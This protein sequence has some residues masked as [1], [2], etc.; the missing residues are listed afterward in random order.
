MESYFQTQD[1]KICGSCHRDTICDLC[2][3]II[4]SSITYG[5]GE[6]VIICTECERSL[7]EFDVSLVDA[8]QLLFHPDILE[9]QKLGEK[10]ST[11]LIDQSDSIS[12]QFIARM[13]LD[14]SYSY[15]DLESV[16][17]YSQIECESSQ[18]ILKYIQNA[19]F[20]T[21]QEIKYRKGVFL[22]PTETLEAGKGNCSSKSAL[23]ASL[24]KAIDLTVFLATM[25]NHCFVLVRYRMHGFKQFPES[26]IDE[27]YLSDF[28]GCDPAS[29]S[30]FRIMPENN[31]SFDEYYIY[32]KKVM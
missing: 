30:P 29:N 2:N 15:D 32:N 23:L 28:I 12:I 24:L 6:K 8:R 22:S 14:R 27:Y 3:R 4:Y 7:T 11:Y 26:K 25:P 18:A 5:T 1:G 17:D 9:G 21:S 16:R 19:Y 20:L 31:Y 10:I 13:I